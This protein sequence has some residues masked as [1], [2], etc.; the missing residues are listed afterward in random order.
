MAL[1]VEKAF[2]LDDP[3]VTSLLAMAATRVKDIQ[4]VTLGEIREALQYASANGW[5]IDQLVRGDETQRGLRDIVDEVY[6]DRARTIARTELGEA[7][8]AATVARY[9]EAGVKAVEILD[10]GAEDDD[11]E[12]KVANGQVWSV[13][14]FAKNALE[15][16]NC[17]RAAAPV[18]GDVTL[19]RG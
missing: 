6:K 18:F 13:A 1:G 3:L 19:D 8:N 12:C 11:E 17:T 15:H 10:N 16:P 2:D 4:D 5:S 14:Y 7:Q 9:K